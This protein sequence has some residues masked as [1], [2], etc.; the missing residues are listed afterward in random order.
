[1]GCT[2][3]SFLPEA[4]TWQM[5]EL[6]AM[7][8]P[9]CGGYIFTLPKIEKVSPHQPDILRLK[10]DGWVFNPTAPNDLSILGCLS[11]RDLEQM[12]QAINMATARVM[13]TQTKNFHPSLRHAR[14]LQYKMAVLAE[15]EKINQNTALSKG[16]VWAHRAVRVRRRACSARK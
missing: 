12:I 11:P 13:A 14:N 15:I 5:H 2:L 10:G 7:M 8:T 1:M 4:E 3:S 16:C 6:Q 9:G